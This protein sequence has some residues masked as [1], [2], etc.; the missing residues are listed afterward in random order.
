MSAPITVIGNWFEGVLANLGLSSGLVTLILAVLGVLIV[1]SFVLIIDIGLVW[2][3]R[4]V[5]ARFQDRLGPNRVGPFGLIQPIA[6]V[7]KL[8]IKED[9]TP[10]GADRI[11]YNLAPILALA[12]V[13]LIWAVIPFAPTLVG[14]EINVGVLFIVA[15]G[16]IGTLGILMAGWAS[17]NKYALLG[18]FRTVAQVISYEVPMLI[19]LLV[20]VLLARTMSVQGI[21]QEQEIWY[22]L[23]APVSA[24]IFFLTGIAEIGRT[25]FDLLE[26]E[27]EIVAGFHI[28]YSGMKFGLFYAG[29]LLHALTI[30]VLFTTLFL[31]GWR[32]PFVEQVPILGVVYLFFKAFLVYFVI[33]WIRYSLPRIRIDHMLNLNWKFLTPL[34]LV[35]LIAT[36]LMDKILINASPQGYALGMLIVNIVIILI[37]L[38][39]LHTYAVIKRERV[40]E[41]RPTANPDAAI[42]SRDKTPEISTL[43]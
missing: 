19:A 3:E 5:V 6:D 39:I 32:G 34:A 25:P 2:L 41:H 29:E 42:S 12:T 14:S 33:M 18:A 43:V 16:A 37:T 21:V 35:A 38:T 15:V 22:V 17:N 27:S 13:L 11:I 40:G 36:A 10:L 7:V 8:L 4:K 26:A 9:T 20:P 24:L 30:G 23:M 31:G 1:I 28:E